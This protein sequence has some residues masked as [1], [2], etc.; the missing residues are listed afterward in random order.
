MPARLRGAFAVLLTDWRRLWAFRD[1][2]GLRPLFYRTEGDRL[3]V[4]SEAKQVV[5]GAQIRKEPDVDGLTRLFFGRYLEEAPS[6]LRGVR[7]L[8]AANVLTAE[9]G[10]VQVTRYWQPERLLETGRFSAS[11]LTDRFALHMTRA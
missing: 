2:V 1:H 10:S 3:F 9:P 8:P 4:A 6:A 11:E 7:R 5:A